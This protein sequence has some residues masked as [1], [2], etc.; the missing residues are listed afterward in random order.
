[1]RINKKIT[2]LFISF[3]AVIFLLPQVGLAQADVFGANALQNTNL[4]TKS[5]YD[6]IVG[7]INVLL[8]F[9]GIITVG[10]MLYGGFT[11]MTSQG[12]PD[13]ID[14]AKKTLVNGV[15]GLMIILSA[16]ALANYILNKAFEA[17]VLS[18]GPGGGGYSTGSGLGADVLDSHYPARYAVNVARNTNIY[19]TFREDMDSSFVLSAGCLNGAALCLNNTSV[20]IV[21]DDTGVAVSGANVAVTINDPAHPTT[22]GFNPYNAVTGEPGLLGDSGSD[23]LYRVE[24]NNLSTALGEPAF[25]LGSYIWEFTV[26]TYVDEIPPEVTFVLPDG[27][28]NPYPINSVVQIN[29]SEA[30]NPMYTAGIVAG[31]VVPPDL[32]LT[33]S[34]GGTPIDGQFMVSNQYRTSEFVTNSFCGV[35]SCGGNVYCLPPL[36]T[37]D[38]LVMETVED[39]AGNQLN[40]NDVD[41]PGENPGDRYPW[42]FVTSDII[43]LTEPYMTSKDAGVDI[44]LND[45]IDVVF[46]KTL[47]SS[48]INGGN[49]ALFK[50]N[51][52]DSNYWFIMD[53]TVLP[54]DTIHIMHDEFDPLTNYTATST[55]NISDSLQNCWYPCDCQGPTCDCNPSTYCGAGGCTTY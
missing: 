32:Y 2:V 20:R 51:L 44:D 38:G 17:T 4:G 27:T 43:D 42:S 9:L 46:S 52:G 14:K 26:G 3:L 36:L 55:S 50:N 37:I 19:V 15:I 31:G 39:M 24:L 16:Y 28:N 23:T 40:F 53:T 41:P 45:S 5:I 7:V 11:W 22:F 12:N 6:T 48:S 21:R 13:K 35:N 18:G 54:N 33:V 47:L 25:G 30:V 10:I 34:S 29:F 1:M 49:L 8:G